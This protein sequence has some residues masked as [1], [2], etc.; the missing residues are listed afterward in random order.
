[1]R[2]L[3]L[4]MA[5]YLVIA[6]PFPVTDKVLLPTDNSAL[7]S[8]APIE[9]P[10]VET[11]GS[12]PPAGEI[13]ASSH[14]FSSTLDEA[15]V[16]IDAAKI[17]EVLAHLARPS[18]RTKAEMCETLAASAA[19]HDL[20]VGF[21]VRLIQQES[22]FNPGAVSAVGA[23]GVAQFMP[24]VA[25]EWGLDD[26]FD[27]HQALPASARFL[28]SLHRQFGNWGLAAAAYNGGMGRLQKWLD[29]RGPLPDETRKYVLNITGH[30]AEKWASGS[31]RNV[32]FTVPTRAPCKDL[33]VTASVETVPLPRPRAG[34]LE[35]SA[36]PAAKREKFLVAS[37]TVKIVTTAAVKTA[38]PAAMK[39]AAPASIMAEGRK[40]SRQAAVINVAAESKT[41]GPI[42][43]ASADAKKASTKGRVQVADARSSRK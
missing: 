42:K 43:L 24:K 23:Q 18:G 38:T 29:K 33:V 10:P 9:P 2:I 13:K 11:T 20:P 25:E 8:V 26:P 36:A 15:S 17:K 39:I 21:F 35:A 4:S 34:T 31:L 30:A 37:R 6:V 5:F 16:F 12:V 32:D 3:L 14:P 41:K 28:R 22:G 19:V 7:A 1:M 27:P 40:A